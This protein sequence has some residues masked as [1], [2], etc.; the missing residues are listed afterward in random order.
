ML[1][2]LFLYEEGG[3]DEPDKMGMFTAEDN[4]KTAVEVLE[5]LGHI[6]RF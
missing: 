1:R 4:K 5:G 3:K 2:R 6:I